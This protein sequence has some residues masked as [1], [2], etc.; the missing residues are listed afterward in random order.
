LIRL[1]I[2]ASTGG[3][4]FHLYY[5]CL[6]A[7]LERYCGYLRHTGHTGDVMAESRGRT[8]DEELE[9]AYRATYGEGTFLGY[10]DGPQ[11]RKTLTSKEI[12]LKP[13]ASNIPG[14][15][16][17]DVLAA[18]VKADVLAEFGILPAPP[19]FSGKLSRA[20]RSSGSTTGTSTTGDSKGTAWFS[21]PARR[22]ARIAE[23]GHAYHN[24]RRIPAEQVCSLGGF[25]RPKHCR[26]LPWCARRGTA[27]HPWPPL[28]AAPP[29][30]A[31]R[32]A[33]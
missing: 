27:Q 26:P 4:A 14:L 28:L 6:D 11:V 18:V 24:R 15:Q 29:G 22:S 16:L 32:P 25:N 10:T 23:P 12:K 9:K 2:A 7:V 5:Y 31:C 21:C 17:A 20:L 19:G 3:Q 30:C 1:L 13:K 8:F 33:S